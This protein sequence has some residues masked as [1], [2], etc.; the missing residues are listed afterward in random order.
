MRRQARTFIMSLRR[1]Q[2]RIARFF[3]NYALFIVILIMGVIIYSTI[4]NIA[5]VDYLNTDAWNSRAAWMGTTS[6]EVFNQTVNIQLEGYSD[7]SFYYVHWGHH[8]FNGTMPYAHGFGQFE[9]DG[10]TN[11]NGAYIFPPLYAVLYAFGIMLNPVNNWAIGVLL[12]IFGYITVF[13]TYGIMYEFT[14]S[15]RAAEVAALTYILS[16]FVLYHTLVV[17]LN[18]AP[19]VFFFFSGFYMLIRGHRHIGTLLIVTGAL[20]KQIVWF[21]GIALVVFLILKWREERALPE[22]EEG[23]PDIELEKLDDEQ[24]PKRSI[25]EW[26]L[27]T[28][29]MIWYILSITVMSAFL[30]FVLLFIQMVIGSLAGIAIGMQIVMISLSIITLFVSISVWYA[31]KAEMSLDKFRSV[32]IL[33]AFAASATMIGAAILLGLIDIMY[34]LQGTVANALIYYQI[35]QILYYLWWPMTTILFAVF[36]IKPEWIPDSLKALK[37]EIDTIPFIKSVVIVLIFAGAICAP[38]LLANPNTF[39]RN[40]A[41]AAGGFYLEDFVN[42]PK[43][44]APMRFQVLPIVLGQP[45]LAAILND[46]VFRG[47]LLWLGVFII[48]VVILLTPKEKEHRMYYMRRILFL[49]L[50]L[51]LWV[52]LMGP[53]GV[54]KYYFVLFAPFFSIFSSARMAASKEEVVPFSASMLYMPILLTAMI[55]IPN[56][57]VYLFGVI[58]I[59]IAYLIAPQI[60]TFWYYVKSPFRVIRKKTSPIFQPITQRYGRIKQRIELLTQEEVMT[61]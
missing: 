57:T 13:P 22:E 44:S 59:M 50:I 35:L 19:V 33:S 20:F 25:P 52:H 60:G 43:Y 16:P 4:F 29:E 61:S 2:K 32:L 54:F 10:I 46:I 55:I 30:A 31:R 23:P 53:R 9:M 51:M 34:V 26:L 37:L 5:L 18:T 1:L 24:K 41:L 38:F 15:R 48:C 56:R 21:L 8:F 40:I 6:F 3:V 49:C 36:V 12:S 58:I 28:P 39:F 11:N 17:W 27:D 47:I 14:K 42:L 7:Y 45:D